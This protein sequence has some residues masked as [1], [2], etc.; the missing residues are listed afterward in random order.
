[1]S[2]QW[3]GAHPPNAGQIPV[4]TSILKDFSAEA[5]GELRTWLEQN[6]PAV[7]ISSIIGFDQF[8]ANVATDVATNETTTSTAFGD[9]ATVGPSLSGIPN[10]KYLLLFGFT[11]KW[12]VAQTGQV[13][14]VSVNSAGAADG[15]ACFVTPAA[16]GGAGTEA[17]TMRVVAKTLSSGSNSVVTKYRATQA[18]NTANFQY[19]WL[20]ALRYANT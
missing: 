15:D 16:T 5:L 20:V 4:V 10:G 19:R 9:L 8:T 3:L 18:G 6:P 7:T 2:S 12:T 11:G 17:S 1:V 14:S 13:M